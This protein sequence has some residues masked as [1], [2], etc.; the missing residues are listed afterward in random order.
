MEC[1]DF[2]IIETCILS[3]SGVVEGRERRGQRGKRKKGTKVNKRLRYHFE[4]GKVRKRRDSTRKRNEGDET[5]KREVN[6]F[7]IGILHRG[8]STDPFVKGL[9]GKGSG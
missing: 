8:Q 3:S 4:I 2:T 9:M 7:R 5:K 6:V 1:Q